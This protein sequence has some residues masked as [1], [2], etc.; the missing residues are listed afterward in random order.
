MASQYSPKIPPTKQ[1]RTS[2]LRNILVTHS[3]IGDSKIER[4][5]SS[6]ASS[7]RL[8]DAESL[9]ETTK[10]PEEEKRKDL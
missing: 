7:Q 8:E 4:R 1:K 2:P 10:K 5:L 3:H 6:N 9:Q